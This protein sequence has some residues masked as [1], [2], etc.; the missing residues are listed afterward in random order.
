LSLDNPGKVIVCSVVFQTTYIYIYDTLSKVNNGSGETS[1]DI[2]GGFF[3]NGQIV[4]P[5]KKWMDDHN[6]IPCNDR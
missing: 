1:Y 3:K 5:S 2:F 6:R 4:K